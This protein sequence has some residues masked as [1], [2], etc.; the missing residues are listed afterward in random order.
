M[1]TR[2]IEFA[3]L[4][5][6]IFSLSVYGQDMIAN[7]EL[8]VR[9]NVGVGVTNPAYGLEVNGTIRAKKAFVDPEWVL[10]QWPDFVFSK[11]YKLPQ[12]T[13]VESHVQEHGHLPG[14]PS[15]AEAIANGVD[16]AEI[17]QNLLQKVEELMLYI[18]GQNKRLSLQKEEIQSLKE[19]LE[20]LQ[21]QIK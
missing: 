13:E 16:L 5:L 18:I 10:M 2:R 4:L 1:R 17:N 15:A 7:S 6:S 21:R 19:T 3:L 8:L 9:D 20:E 14:F 11:E 12:L